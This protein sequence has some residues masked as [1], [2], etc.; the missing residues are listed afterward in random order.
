VTHGS[1]PSIRVVGKNSPIAWNLR[2]RP[3][4]NEPKAQE[5]LKHELSDLDAD[6]P[7]VTVTVFE[8]KGG[9]VH[10]TTIV[11]GFP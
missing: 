4:P 2:S 11:P 7:A 5:D 9:D 1:I 10:P 3:P 8:Q 6:T